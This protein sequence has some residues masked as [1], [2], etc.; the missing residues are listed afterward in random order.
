MPEV[1]STPG[2]QTINLPGLRNTALPAREQNAYKRML[3]CLQQKQFKQGLKAGKQILT[4][5]KYS[6]HTETLAIQGLL[7]LGI[8]KVEEAEKTVREGLKADLRSHS[9]WNSL[10]LIQKDLKKYSEAIKCF[11]N[12]LKLEPKN[13]EVLRNLSVLCI[14]TRDLEGYRDTRFNILQLKP[15]QR[16]SWAALALSYHLLGDYEMAV[17]LLDELYM[18]QRKVDREVVGQFIQSFLNKKT[19]YDIEYSEIIK[20]HIKGNPAFFV[21]KLESV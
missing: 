3:N 10:A 8:G 21:W 16:V 12:C 19:E 13:E 7:L 14:Q 2:V 4:N 11:R 9:C 15:T 18:S 1:S 17:K 20:Y 5:S 6:N